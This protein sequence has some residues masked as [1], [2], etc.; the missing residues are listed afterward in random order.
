MIFSYLL[1]TTCIP[2]TANCVNGSVNLLGGAS[3]SEGTVEVCING[4]Y[5]PVSL[6]DGLFTV[7]ESSVICRQL[8]LGNGM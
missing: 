7:K 5:Y 6:Q 4:V 2:H 3:D 8:G 1:H